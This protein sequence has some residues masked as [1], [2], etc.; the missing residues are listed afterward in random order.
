MSDRTTRFAAL[1]AVIAAGVAVLL[2][3]LLAL[4]YFA[5]A[6]GAEALEMGTVSAWADPARDLVGGLVTW[7]SPERV[8]ATY[9]QVFALLFPAIF[10]CALAVRARRPAAAGRLERWGW[11][12]ALFGYGLMSLGLIAASVVLVDASA[13]V[14]GSAG[15]AALDV[16][17]ISLMLPGMAISVIGSTVLGIGLLRNRYE[18]TVT[19]GL[20]ALAFPS[21]L[22]LSTLLGHNSLALL[23]VFVAWALTGFQLWRAGDRA[24]TRKLPEATQRLGTRH[25]EEVVVIATDASR[26]G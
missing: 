10:L 17:F 19:A 8:Y 18:P 7:A 22:A 16:V 14:E 21:M 24:P 11:R 25:R 26:H 13:A 23:P 5:T 6:D 15:Y 2:S 12:I 4:A 20:L 3:P 9:V 1:Y